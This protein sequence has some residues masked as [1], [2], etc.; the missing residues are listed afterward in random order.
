M[1]GHFVGWYI[2]ALYLIGK[3]PPKEP[4][5]SWFAWMRT[6]R[7]G[8]MTL[9]L[10]LAAIVTVLIAISVYGFGKEGILETIVGSRSFYYW[11]VLHVTLSFLPR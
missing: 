10:G 7:K 5:K 11:T 2:F 4:P 1:L 3:H 9:H 6:T 8:F